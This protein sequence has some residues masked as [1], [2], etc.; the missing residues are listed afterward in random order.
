MISVSSYIALS[1]RSKYNDA[2]AMNC[3]GMTNT[4]NDQG[5]TDTHD[6]RHSANIATVVF[7]L[8]LAATAGGVVLYL[9]APKAPASAEH[10]FY[11]VPTVGA[12]GAAV[13]LGGRL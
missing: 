10:A 5:L 4:C 9:L 12:D 3:M 11:L 1:A 8:G 7:S 2:L 6:A 13:V